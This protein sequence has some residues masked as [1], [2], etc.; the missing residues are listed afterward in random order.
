MSIRK[1]HEALR[2]MGAKDFRLGKSI[3]SYDLLPVTRRLGERGR[4]SYEM[5]FRFAQDEF[6]KTN[7]RWNNTGGAS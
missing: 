5:G 2:E 4:A 1:R 7:P 3:S 6:R